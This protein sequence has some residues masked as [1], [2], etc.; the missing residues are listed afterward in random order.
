VPL[1]PPVAQLSTQFR[2]TQKPG[3]DP[4]FSVT[5]VLALS[6]CGGCGPRT[7]ADWLSL[8][9]HTGGMI[10][11][12]LDELWS[13]EAELRRRLHALRRLRP[14]QLPEASLVGTLWAYSA[15]VLY[16]AQV[17]K[18][19]GV[20]VVGP[21]VGDEPESLPQ[22]GSGRRFSLDGE[23][24][25]LLGEDVPNYHL[26]ADFDRLAELYELCVRP[27][28]TP[29][30]DEALAIIR[31][32]LAPE[33]RVLDAGC[34]P[35]R[36]ARRVAKLVPQGEVV[37]VDL[38]AGMVTTAH[39]A[40]RA[41]RL[42]NCAFVQA[43]VGELPRT[44]AEAFDIVYSCLAHHHYPDPRAAATSVLRCLRPGGIYCVIDPGPAWFNALSSPL[45]RFADPGWIGFKTPDEFRALLDAAGFARVC[46]I[47]LLPGI[48][49]AVGQKAFAATT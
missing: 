46:W 1:A 3:S 14:I 13:R 38:A 15:S 36:E 37:G 2:H 45:G 12:A 18:R 49:M 16:P 25:V 39:A 44:F 47:P 19:G 9:A 35:G 42:R 40:A 28:S 32:F 20:S 21:I 41:R 17:L 22:P 6:H 24:P 26:V 7:H 8:R 34:G 10:A 48:G 4:C 23:A 33:S 30:F 31:R 5:T 43:D 11:D 29:I 27:F